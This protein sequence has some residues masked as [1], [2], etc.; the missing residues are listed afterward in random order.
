MRKLNQIGVVER[1]PPRGTYM[2]AWTEKDRAEILHLLDALIL[3]SVELSVGYL[4]EETFAQLE[5]IIADT[6]ATAPGMI[7][8][9]FQTERD[10]NFHLI[11]ARASGSRRLVEFMEQLM[12]P[13][14]LYS[15]ESDEYFQPDFWLRIH[16]GLLEALRTGDLDTAVACSLRNSRESR[17]V[18]LRKSITDG[19]SQLVYSK[20]QAEG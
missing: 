10:A 11:I 20:Q 7:D 18:L 15:K 5:Q 3:L 14:Q 6:R 13:L 8:N 16:S 1:R 17:A 9:Q 19:R 4:T 12:L 2:R